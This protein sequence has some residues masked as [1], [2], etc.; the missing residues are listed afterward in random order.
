MGH[1]GRGRGMG[2][3]IKGDVV[4]IPFP[5]S[6]NKIRDTINA[7]IKIISSL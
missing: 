4:I 7:I 2:K 1:A 5:F 6:E 3:F